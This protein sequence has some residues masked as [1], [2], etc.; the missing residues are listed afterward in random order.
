[1]QQVG[2]KNKVMGEQARVD[3][4]AV[5]GKWDRWAQTGHNGV[6]QQV[7]QTW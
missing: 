4:G 2:A 7:E 3:V 6:V 5:S 1:V